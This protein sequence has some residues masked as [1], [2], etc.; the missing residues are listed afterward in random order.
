MILEKILEQF[1]DEKIARAEG[2]DEAVIG[3]DVTSMKLIYSISKSIEIINDVEIFS[4]I[5]D[6]SSGGK[7]YIWCHDYLSENDILG[8]NA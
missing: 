1:K 8:D 3:I 7:D 6:A 2:L 4:S 5:A